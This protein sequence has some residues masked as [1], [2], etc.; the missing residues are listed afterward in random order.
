[1]KK[2]DILLAIAIMFL[3]SGNFALIKTALTSFS[4]FTFNV[5]RV[6]I[7]SL[8]A[9]PFIQ[10]PKGR[11]KEALL[12][13][14]IFG[15][16][17]LS[18]LIIAL[19]YGM[20][21]STTVIIGQTG[22]PFSCILGS[23]FLKDKLGARRSLA[24]AIAFIGV[25]IFAGTPNV[26]NNIIGFSI[27][28]C[29]F[30]FW[31]IMNVYSKAKLHDIPPIT[32]IGWGLIF[33]LPLLFIIMLFTDGIPIEMIKNARSI[34]FIC[35]IV[36]SIFPLLLANIAWQYL[37]NK[38]TVSSVAPFAL[39]VP[40]F[41]S[42]FGVMIFDDVFTQSM[43]IG[44]ALIMTGVAVIVWRQPSVTKMGDS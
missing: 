5:A 24:L 39:L 11:L 36:S 29:S 15:F 20:D 32:R 8:F 40:F 26:S 6:A 21:V 12:M 23:I 18:L 17:H 35:L 19:S 7:A 43:F 31:A 38:Y 14:F 2:R 22:V 28:I 37:L 9:L 3:W 41:G 42:F 1:M 13:G 16:G 33:S 4:P 34:D 10:L 25:F 30:V 27:L 44:G